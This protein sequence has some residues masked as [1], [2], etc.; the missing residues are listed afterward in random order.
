[1]TG[2]F[3]PYFILLYEYLIVSRLTFKSST[4]F[5]LIFVNVPVC[6]V[7][8]VVSD[9]VQP[10][11]LHTEEPTRPLCPWDFPGRD[12]GVG[13]FAL[14]QGIFLTQVSNSCLLCILHL[15]AGSLPLAPPG[16]PFCKWYQVKFMQSHSFSCE[17]PVFPAPLNIQITIEY[18]WLPC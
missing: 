11:G 1:M 14:L 18:S 2:G 7:A 16:K 6:H 13:C 4:N 8:S 17:Y 12:A 3:F 10:H 5:E 9:T 15:Q